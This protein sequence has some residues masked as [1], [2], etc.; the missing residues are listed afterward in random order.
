MSEAPKFQLP[1][2]TPPDVNTAASVNRATFRVEP[3]FVIAHLLR[4]NARAVAWRVKDGAL[5]EFDVQSDPLDILVPSR[6]VVTM[7]P[8][9]MVEKLLPVG[10]RIRE[11]FT[12]ED[13]TLE[14]VFEGIDAPPSP[15]GMLPKMR[16]NI[17]VDAMG[18]RST[19][20]ESLPV[21]PPVAP[22][23]DLLRKLRAKL[24]GHGQQGGSV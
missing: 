10:N 15:D 3:L 22:D 23:D 19:W 18:V 7:S 8:L 16:L 12:A 6:C 14:Y 24:N 17:Q 2:F 11:C 21:S 1:D 20:I 4:R 5:I 13:G 9:A